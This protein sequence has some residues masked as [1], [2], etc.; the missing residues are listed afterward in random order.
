[1]ARQLRTD[2]IMRLSTPRFAVFAVLLLGALAARAEPNLSAPQVFE[3]LSKGRLLLIDIRTP[4]EWRQ[5]GVVPGAAR[6]DYYRGPEVLLKS[7]LKMVDGDRNAAIA[8]VCR[9][10]NR[11]ARAQ[12]LLQAQGFTQVYNLNEGMIGSAA[13]PGWLKRQLPVE[14]C[15]C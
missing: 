9:T 5:T 6:V 7:V 15:A 14:P 12:K 1:M 4:Q 13:G 3:A 10:G 8:L 11:T 2:L